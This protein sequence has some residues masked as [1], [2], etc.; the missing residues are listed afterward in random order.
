M[1]CRIKFS[2]NSHTPDTHFFVSVGD[3][4]RVLKYKWRVEHSRA[5]HYRIVRDAS[6]QERAEGHPKFI[7]LHRFILN[8]PPK[9]RLVIDH[10]N[11]WL[12]NRRT[13]LRK[14]TH[15]ENMQNRGTHKRNTSGFKGVVKRKDKWAAQIISEGVRHNLGTF[16]TFEEAK[17][18]YCEAA[19]KLHGEF[20]KL[21]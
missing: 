10:I 3:L 11:H 7:K 20:A 13:A 21:S 19:K 8:I 9:E 4:Q 16:P 15:T 14:A 1:R 12:D 5:E 17:N 6:K 18:A 2:T